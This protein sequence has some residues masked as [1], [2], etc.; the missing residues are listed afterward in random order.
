MAATRI[1]IKDIEVFWM[2]KQN[3]KQRAIY[4]FP[5]CAEEYIKQVLKKMRYRRK[6]RQDVQVELAAHFEDE[7]KDCKTDEKREQKAKQL[8]TEFGDVKLLAV[9]LR[10][11]KKRCRPFWRTVIARTF[12]TIGVLML[13]FILYVFWFFSGEP[14]ISVDYLALLNQMDQPQV[15]DE[16]N[17]WSH[18]E[19][20][21]E[22]FVE[23]SQS[24]KKVVTF[25]G[26]WWRPTYRSFAELDEDNKREIRKWIEQ[27]EAAWREFVAG[28]EK[29]YCYC[30]WE[31]K[32]QDQLLWEVIF[33]T[34]DG[35]R[36][37]AKLGIWRSRIAV[38]NGE[39]NKA[40]MECVTITRVGK[41]WQNKKGIVAEQRRG[42]FL[43]V[44]AWDEIFFIV[45]AQD[46]SASD[47]IKTKEQL[48]D[49]YGAG[50][51]LLDIEQERPYFLDMVQQFFTQGGPGG[52]HVLPGKVRNLLFEL[53]DD[54]T[55]KAQS[56]VGGRWPAEVVFN[57][58]CLIHVGR[59]ETVAK[60]D[61]IYHE[62]S[63]LIKMTPYE[64]HVKG[65]EVEGEEISLQL[66]KQKRFFLMGWVMPTLVLRFSD[67]VYCGKSQY[68]ALLTILALQHW[69]LD[70]GT[71]PDR[72]E[73]LVKGSYLKQLPTDPYSDKS[74]V[75]KKT[76]DDFALY[77]VGENFRDDAGE[78]VRYS[79]TGEIARWGFQKF[80][81]AVFWPAPKSDIKQ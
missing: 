73:E 34:L 56:I 22:L 62:M 67:W 1:G 57:A 17:A 16:D 36:S 18:Y 3:E 46:V 29:G 15:R 75:Y 13:C 61:E 11:A 66:L 38:A 19:K 71:Y 8:I 53:V 4:R 28:S 76:D 78:V 27:N 21:V 31:R 54:M 74:L 45:A 72:L 20:A 44:R 79:R 55:E 23:P 63:E 64:R 12:Q 5:A 30:R 77:S 81:D 32:D 9:L 35:L 52:G 40:L 37:L 80:G 58:F 42:L 68:E 60:F 10:R 47:L 7:L 33:S 43:G 50:F 41:H 24:I 49:I 6:V 2:K 65:I 39:V 26:G 69:R 48:E 51:P 59:D 25:S 14:S 70:K